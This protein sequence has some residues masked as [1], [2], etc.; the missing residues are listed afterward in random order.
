M[1]TYQCGLLNKCAVYSGRSVRHQQPDYPE[2]NATGSL[3]PPSVSL[4]F[5]L[6]STQSSMGVS[7]AELEF[8]FHASS[9]LPESPAIKPSISRD[10]QTLS[11]CQDSL[12][13][14]MEVPCLCY[15]V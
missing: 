11:Q 10:A 12:K 8:L 5:L 15:K 14:K 7:K 13:T 9:L 6:G 4:A 1:E 2:D 3:F